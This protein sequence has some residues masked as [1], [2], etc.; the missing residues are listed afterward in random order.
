MSA[1]V[2]A[3]VGAVSDP[4]LRR[5]LSELDMV[6]DITVDAGVAH[7]AIALTI[8]GCPAAE[9]ISAEVTAAAAG[10]PGVREVALEVG[11]MTADERRALTARLRGS[12][13]SRTI[14]FG[15]DSLTRVIA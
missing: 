14:P 10:V 11:V 4:E 2:R 15:P 5:P 8:V 7:V 3:A 9:R 6:R 12:R 1:S 13:A